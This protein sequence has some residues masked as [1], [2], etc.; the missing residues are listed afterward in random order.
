M[1]GTVAAFAALSVLSCTDAFFGGTPRL[2]VGHHPAARRVASARPM[3]HSAP[4][5]ISMTATSEPEVE[6]VDVKKDAAALPMGVAAM[7]AEMDNMKYKD[8]QSAYKKG[9]ITRVCGPLTFVLGPQSC[10]ADTCPH[11]VVPGPHLSRVTGLSA[12]SCAEPEGHADA[13]ARQA[14]A[15]PVRRLGQKEGEVHR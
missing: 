15:Q 7:L 13:Q 6:I 2:P 1:R 3:A 8:I 10:S 9:E 12:G 11:C 4:F 5:S 14:Q